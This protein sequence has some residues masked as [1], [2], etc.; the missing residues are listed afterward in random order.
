MR[1]RARRRRWRSDQRW[2]PFNFHVTSLWSDPADDEANIA[3]TRE[4][5]AAMKPFTTGRVYINFIG[6]EGEERVVA[7][8]GAEGYA[9]LQAIK[10]RYDPD[11]LF[12]SSQNIKPSRR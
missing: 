5:S 7:A 9:R 10:D 3:W 2:A 4:L 1:A 12:R 6:D 11:N 8:F